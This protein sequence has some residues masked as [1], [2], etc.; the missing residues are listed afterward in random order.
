MLVEEPEIGVEEAGDLG[1]LR[2]LKVAECG[3]VVD[4]PRDEDGKEG[5][6]FVDGTGTGEQRVPAGGED[7]GEDEPG[8]C[9]RNKRLCRRV[10]VEDLP[11]EAG[12][13]RDRVGDDRGTLLPEASG[14][15]PCEVGRRDDED[16]A[17]R[18]A[19]GGFLEFCDETGEAFSR[20][21]GVQKSGGYPV[22]SPGE[23]LGEEEG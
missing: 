1:A 16:G 18:V 2:A 13:G 10:L 15:L 9:V 21:L 4:L 12:E 3:R 19:G 6:E 7:V 5:R 11:G 14:D 17:E 8:L 23:R 22:I 20:Q